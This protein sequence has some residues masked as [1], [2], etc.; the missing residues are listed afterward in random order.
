MNKNF[1]S[2]LKRQLRGN[3]ITPTVKSLNTKLQPC[4]IKYNNTLHFN[5][6]LYTKNI[7]SFFSGNKA[8]KKTQEKEPEE[9]EKQQSSQENENNKEEPAKEKN[10]KVE[11]ESKTNDSVSLRDFNNLK[12]LYDDQEKKLSTAR[13]KFDEL[14]RAFLN[15]Q[16]ETK[17]ILERNKT[18][19]AKTKDF[20]ITSFAKDLLDVHDNFERAVNSLNTDSE[21]TAEQKLEIFVEGIQMTHDSLKRIFAKHGIQE[22]NPKSQKFN[23]NE[24][25]AMV[26]IEHEEIKPGHVAETIQTGFKIGT[27]ILRPAKVGVVK[28]K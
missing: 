1:L 12:E 4:I 24:H 21:L 25:E 5:A 23:P 16:E 7:K 17:R 22:F 13:T 27:R 9:A 6:N 28:N 20:A 26:Q 18:E 2:S 8:E 14:R 3:L 11:N 15:N 10:S 19:L